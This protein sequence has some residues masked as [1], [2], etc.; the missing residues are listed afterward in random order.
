MTY[1]SISERR[2]LEHFATL[3]M[4]VVPMQTFAPRLDPEYLDG[5][6]TEQWAKPDALAKQPLTFTFI[7]AKN[8]ILNHHPSKASC[9]WAL[10]LEYGL[11]MNDGRDKDY[12]NLT[13]HFRQANFAFLMANSWNNSL[14]KVLA[15]QRLHG[16]QR[17]LVVFAKSPSA[18]DAK[19]YA[20]A[21]LVFC[22]NDT[23][24]QMLAVIELAAHGLYYTFN[25]R[26][27]RA[28][29]QITVNPEP[30][31]AHAGMSPEQITDAN[32]AAYEAVVAVRKAQARGER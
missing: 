3:P 22:T 29:Y 25:F 20:E 24:A 7:E 23:L 26:A 16:W 31:P 14:F 21:G 32:R 11:T 28:K 6:G 13:K 18:L 1:M 17:Y 30:N 4:E 12:N 19:R 9:H 8:G 2:A 27:T 10:Q 5:D 15:L